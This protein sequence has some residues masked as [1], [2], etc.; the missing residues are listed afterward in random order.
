MQTT[1]AQSESR[2]IIHIDM[3]CFYTTIELRERP[4]LVGR[5][6]A[7]GGCPGGRV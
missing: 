1:V 3:D 5:P 4:E 6:V 7:V 2:Q